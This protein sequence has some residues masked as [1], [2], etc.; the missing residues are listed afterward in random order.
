MIAAALAWLKTF[1]AS[2][3][4]VAVA[5]MVLA[6]GTWAVVA[7]ARY[8]AADKALLQLQAEQAQA[9]AQAV[10]EARAE[11]QRRVAAQAEIANDAHRKMEI[12]QRNA[13]AARAAAQRLYARLAAAAANPSGHSAAA[14]AGAP[15]GDTNVVPADVYRRLLGAARRLGDR[16]VDLADLAD[17]RGIT[18][19][20][21]ERAYDSLTVK[22]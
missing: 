6:L 11:E 7:T 10:T 22:P 14:S 17:R 13:D 3:E 1:F 8:D 16:G 15:A 5:A 21:C 4:T 12:A 20:A 18:G 2:V 19:T 9:I